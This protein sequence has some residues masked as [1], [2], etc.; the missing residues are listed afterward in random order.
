MTVFLLGWLP[1]LAYS[2]CTVLHGSPGF[3][4]AT[5]AW[6]I[7]N[8]LH[9]YLSLAWQAIVRPET[10]HKNHTLN[11]VPYTLPLK[12]KYKSHNNPDSQQAFLFRGCKV[13]AFQKAGSRVESSEVVRWRTTCS[14]VK[15]RQTGVHQK[16]Q[17]EG[18]VER[19][20]NAES[21]KQNMVA[22]EEG[23]GSRY[24]R[25]PLEDEHNKKQLD[26]HSQRNSSVPGELGSCP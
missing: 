18:R 11:C 12:Q 16:V 2:M 14:W 7:T 4:L 25:M 20:Q 8:K 17:R 15:E 21:H 13:V 5:L 1:S 19:H 23:Y 9:S 6:H 26:G 24:C 10:M 22:G 3:S